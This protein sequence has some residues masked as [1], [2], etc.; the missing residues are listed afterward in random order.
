MRGYEELAKTSCF[1]EKIVDSIVVY[2]TTIDA[3]VI[4]ATLVG[5]VLENEHVG[6]AWI[7]GWDD[8]L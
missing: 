8:G 3:M 6:I 1:G 7:K 2:V 5:I 4:V